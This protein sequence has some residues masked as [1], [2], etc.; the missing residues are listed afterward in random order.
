MPDRRTID[1]A[2]APGGWPKPWPNVAEIA[3]HL[4]SERWALVGGLMV[5]L[6]A[7]HHRVGAI[8]PTNDVDIVLHVETFRGAPAATA[9]ALES[10]G[11]R[12]TTPL[13]PRNKS[14][15]RFVRGGTGIDL[16]T[17]TTDSVD[18]LLADHAAPRVVE[19]LRGR[20]MVKIEGGTQ[21]LRRTMNARLN[22][23]AGQTTTISVPDTLGALILK[24]AAYQTD[25]RDRD[26]H[27]YDAAVLLCCIDD[28][29]VERERFAGSD[30]KRLKLLANS[31]PPEHSAW[32]RI[33]SGARGEGLAALR[34]LTAPV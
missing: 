1:V 18:V 14:A 31:L 30:R 16:S 4:P 23:V 7:V 25:S 19:K 8:R 26:R 28:P 10:L 11:Y 27:L 20:T 32:Q 33:P 17:S 6:H 24:A 9:N 29:Y 3:D 2:A 22:I 13:D 12:L 15:H 34:L 21:A 5:Q